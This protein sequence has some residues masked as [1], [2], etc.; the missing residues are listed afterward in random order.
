MCASNPFVPAGCVDAATRRVNASCI[1]PVAAQARPRSIRCPTC[2]APASST[3]TSSRTASSTT[4]STSSTLRRRPH[5]RHGQRQ[6]LRALQLPADR[7]RRAAA[8]RAIRWPRATSPATIFIRGQ[9]AVGG[10]SRVFGSALFSEF[11][12]GYNRVRS[13]SVHPAFGIDAERAV[14]HQRR[15]EGSALLR[16]PAAHADRAASR[17]SAGRSSGRSS[18]PRRCSSSPR[19]SPGPRARH[20]FKFGVERRRD[21]RHLHRPAL[22]E[23]RAVVHRRPLHRLRPRRLPARPVERRSG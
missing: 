7:S 1:D 11:R 5:L 10:W 14:R 12:F 8:A 6:H 15:A 3:T 21:L 19:T 23:R 17:A 13:D 2:P 9:N 20:T 4:T 22:A 18:R 16:R